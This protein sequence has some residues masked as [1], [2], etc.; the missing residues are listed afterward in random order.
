MQQLVYISTARQPFGPESLDDILAT[1]RRN[2]G[3][4]QMTG[5]LLVGGRRLLQALEGPEEAVAA[6]FARIKADPRHFA[7]VELSNK[8]VE[9][10]QFGQWAMAHHSAGSD[11][12]RASLKAKVDELTATLQ[13]RNLRALFAGFADIHAKAA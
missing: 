1:S 4:A 8:R 10:R 13:D 3:A 12:A 5:L 2:N 9:R 6:A 11:D 7:I